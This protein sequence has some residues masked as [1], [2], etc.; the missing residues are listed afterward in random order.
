[1]L[2]KQRDSGQ[3]IAASSTVPP[4]VLQPHGLLPARATGDRHHAMRLM[5]NEYVDADVV[6]DGHCVTSRGAGT[7]LAF[8]PTLVELLC[9]RNEAARV[10]A[11]VGVSTAGPAV[12]DP[13]P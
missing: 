5:L 6:V 13:S 12:S 8:G 10:A 4:L 11:A 3:W 7:A 1:M 2:T 9:G